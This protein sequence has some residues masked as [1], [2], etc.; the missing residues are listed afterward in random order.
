MPTIEE[1]REFWND[2]FHW[3]S[4]RGDVWS[5]HW[6]GVEAQ[7][8]WCVYPRTRSHLPTGTVLEV[9]PGMGRWT[10]FLR[11][12]CENLIVVDISQRCLEVCRARFGDVGMDYHLGD[13]RTLT[14]VRDGSVDFVFSFES[15]IHTEQEDLASYLQ[16]IARVLKPGGS[17]FL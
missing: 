10:H 3:G 7:W 11:A 6:G 12:F 5:D 17:C 8:Q 15:L 13:G 14:P 4:H 16:E 9:G 1:N 2:R